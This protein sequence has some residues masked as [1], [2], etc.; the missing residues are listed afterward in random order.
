VNRTPHTKVPPRRQAFKDALAATLHQADQPLKAI[1]RELGVA[2]SYGYALADRTDLDAVPSVPRL[3][4]ILSIC[5]DP[6]VLDYLASLQGRMTV[7]T[8]VSDGVVT[9]DRLSDLLDGLSALVRTHASALADGSF[10]ADDAREYERNAMRLVRALLSQ[11]TYV[12]VAAG[13]PIRQAV[14]A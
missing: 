9:L 11:I 10:S 8:P 5:T 2:D 4:A 12:Q 14:S 3:M 7:P 6:T 1:F 13:L